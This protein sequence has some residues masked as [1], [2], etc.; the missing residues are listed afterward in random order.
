MVQLY[1]QDIQYVTASIPSPKH[2]HGSHY[3]KEEREQMYAGLPPA[4]K[5]RKFP[6][7]FS[8]K[9]KKN[10]FMQG[11]AACKHH[12][13]NQVNTIPIKSISFSSMYKSDK[14]VARARC[15]GIHNKDLGSA[16]GQDRS[17]PIIHSCN[18]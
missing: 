14:C 8:K 1:L 13:R 2:F 10:L 15:I 9:G 18:S 3:P 7:V 5:E 4:L 11:V 12:K 6:I 16:E 17:A